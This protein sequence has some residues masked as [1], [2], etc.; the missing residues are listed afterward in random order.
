MNNNLYMILNTETGESHTRAFTP[1][2]LGEC[3]RDG[4]DMIIPIK[5]NR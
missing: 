5:G 1:A 3:V 2:Q 4:F